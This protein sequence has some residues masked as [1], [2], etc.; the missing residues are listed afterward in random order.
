MATS[1]TNAFNLDFYVDEIIEE[2]YELAGGQPQ[3]GYDGRSARRSL[4]L[5]LTD[6]QNRG[7][8]LWGTDLQTVTLTYNQ[9]KETLDAST[10]DVLDGYMRAS[11]ENNDLQMTRVSYEEYEGIVD[12]TSTGRPVQFATL[13][14][15]NT[16]SVY[17]WPVPDNTQTYTFR[18]YRVR[19]L[20]DITKSA[21]QNA[22]VPF[23]FLPCLINGLAYYL[24]MKRPNTSGD[25]IMM[26]KANYEETFQSAF[27]ADKQRADMKIV[28]RLGYIN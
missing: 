9:A 17:F 24:S 8:L 10:V 27:E 5:L 7:V 13:R 12:K 14:G 15:E 16:V 19:R 2:A 18:Y 20:Y 22:D 28:P 6:W 1:G 23:R 4:N 26:L 25:R 3:T 21:L 11:N